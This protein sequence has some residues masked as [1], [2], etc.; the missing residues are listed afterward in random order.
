M[1]NVIGVYYDNPIMMKIKNLPEHSMYTCHFENKRLLC[2]TNRD[3]YEL[4]TARSFDTLE[5][6][7]LY[8]AQPRNPTLI[9]TYTP[10]LHAP[11]NCEMEPF[12]C[13]T[14]HMDYVLYKVLET[15]GSHINL[16]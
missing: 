4:L 8:I 5:W 13:D 2:T 10:K 15:T 1:R 11:Y 9:Q 14:N 7:S 16:S 12:C 6:V 3:S